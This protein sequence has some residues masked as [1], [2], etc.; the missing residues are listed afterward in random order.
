[1]SL[2]QRGSN[3]TVIQSNPETNERPIRLTCQNQIWIHLQIIIKQTTTLK[4]DSISC[5]LTN[6]MDSINQKGIHPNDSIK[7]KQNHSH[8]VRIPRIEIAIWRQTQ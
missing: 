4:K 1:M 7:Q 3:P 5:E 8:G 6:R 2:W